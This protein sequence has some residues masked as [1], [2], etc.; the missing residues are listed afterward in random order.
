M[1]WTADCIPTNQQTEPK[2]KTQGG[3][4]NFSGTYHRNKSKFNFKRHVVIVLLHNGWCV[5]V[6]EPGPAKVAV[7][8]SGIP[9]AETVS[10]SSSIIWQEELSQKEADAAAAW[11]QADIL[12]SPPLPA[13]KQEWLLH[14]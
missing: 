12:G 1:E 4:S 14:R 5:C 10:G 7:T 13:G 8:G 6:Q 9:D 2:E 11:P 3:A